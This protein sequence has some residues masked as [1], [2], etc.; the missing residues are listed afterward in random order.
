M[1]D[2]QPPSARLR[3]EVLRL[4][5]LA[6]PVVV[7]QVGMMLMGVVDTLMVGQLG[8]PALAGIN[9]GTLWHFA[10]FVLVMGATNGI[11]P[12]LSQARGADDEAALA[13]AL[14]QGCTLLLAVGVPVALGHLWAEPALLALGQPAAAAALGADYAEVILFALA[15][16]ALFGLFR[17]ALQ[18]RGVVRPAMWLMLAANVFNVGLNALL[19]FG[20]GDW[21]GVGAIGVAYTTTAVRWLVFFGLLAWCG[22]E[23]RALQQGWRLAFDTRAVARLAL[24]ALPVAL[25]GALEVWGFSIAGLIVGKLGETALAAH[26]VVL[27]LASLAFM[28]PLAIGAAASTR[29]GN[30][31]GAGHPPDR[32]AW[33][34]VGMGSGVMVLSGV[35]F[36]TIP[37]VLAAAYLPT[38]PA[39][40][41]VAASVLPIAAGFGAFDGAQAVAF[42]VLRGMGDTRWPAAANVVAYYVLGL[43]LGAWLALERGQG[44]AGVWLGMLV[45]LGVVAALLVARIR[46]VLRRGVT[47]LAL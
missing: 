47:R 2:V 42:G 41:A 25:Q 22:P 9:L 39:A 30:L 33:T 45:A 7:A 5:T 3:D 35:V 34:A 27:N 24:V 36:F 13:R 14:A 32:A 1:H 19:L 38:D 15:P 12:A 21:P 43:P 46:V 37:G 18:A 17:Q 4:A 16:A 11:D 44:V 10:L 8:S 40:A 23:L 29:V 20:V 26:A 6:W 28:V 31:V